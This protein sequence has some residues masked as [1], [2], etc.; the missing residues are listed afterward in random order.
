MGSLTDAASNF[1]KSLFGALPTEAARPTGMARLTRH[2]AEAEGFLGK[3][4]GMIGDVV[5]A[6]ARLV[7]LGSG[8]A[9]RG[10]FEAS[11]AVAAKTASGIGFV[12]KQPVVGALNISGAAVRGARR[13]KLL[14]GGLAA[15]GLVGYAAHR[16]NADAQQRTQDELLAE[17]NH[18]P[19]QPANPY[20]LPYGYHAANVE[21][22]Q[23][24]SMSQGAGG[25]HAD[26]VLAAKQ[27][28]AASQ[29]SAKPTAD[30]AQL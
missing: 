14:A 5:K 11:T 8:A 18:A 4:G 28:A 23:R 10:S 1:R 30:L 20:V 19:A 29:E 6:P 24:D 12:A 9:A 17:M 2:T 7:V 25:G 3:I 21:P 27:A 22:L 26:R 15:L 16:A 13:H